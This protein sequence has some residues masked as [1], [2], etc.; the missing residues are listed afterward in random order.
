MLGLLV[1]IGFQ[2][3]G[4]EIHHLGAPLPGVVI[5]LLLFV[6]ALAT[7]IIKLRWVE[8]TAGFLVRHMTLLFI[9]IM[10]GLPAMSAQLRSAGP[11][12]LASTI[13]SLLAVL[14]AT[15]ALAHYLLR[16]APVAIPREGDSK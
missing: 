12:L 14:F 15:G 7:K 2:L 3:L 9:P 5:G 13:V 6:F 10:A 4:M 1:I 8:R 16:D 11:A